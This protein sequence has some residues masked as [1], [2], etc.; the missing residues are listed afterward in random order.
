MTLF[1]RK[2]TAARAAQTT[3]V[4]SKTKAKRAKTE[5]K[6]N[7][8]VP[9]KDRTVKAKAVTK[10]KRDEPSAE[11][12]PGIEP[13]V[14]ADRRAPVERN[15]METD[16]GIRPCPSQPRP[17]AAS[18]DARPYYRDLSIKKHLGAADDVP[19]DENYTAP[20]A[21]DGPINLTPRVTESERIEADAKRKANTTATNLG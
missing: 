1:G 15:V 11:A 3:A 5:A 7:G 2:R 4:S 17:T 16:S 14:P 13:P 18:E 9:V 19:T 6:P 8:K 21:K 10:T 12:T 20:A